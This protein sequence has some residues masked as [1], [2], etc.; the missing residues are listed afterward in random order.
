M[1]LTA[2]RR[3]F[4]AHGAESSFEDIARE[5]GVGVGTVYRRFPDRRALIEAILEQRVDDVD[6]VAR[7]ALAAPDPWVAVRFFVGSAA[8]MQLED[9]GLRELLHDA[10]FVS[11]GL[12]VLRRRI[13]P[14]AEE[15]ALRLRTEGAARPDLTGRDLLVLIRMLGS[16]APDRPA[17]RA[18]EPVRE[19]VGEADGEFERYLGLVLAGLRR[20]TS[21][22]G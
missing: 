15:L 1:V 22:D 6:A 21:G 18:G 7:E 14:A 19:P 9:R 3:M 4:A 17:P 8:R 10:G 2:A 5:A 16:L 11:A 12:A 13:A 20:Q